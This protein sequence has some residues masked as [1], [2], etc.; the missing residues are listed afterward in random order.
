MISNA[1]VTLIKQ[2]FHKGRRNLHHLLKGRLK[3]HCP[4][5]KTKF[6]LINVRVISPHIT[7]YTTKLDKKIL[8]S[9]TEAVVWKRC[10]ELQG[11]KW[12]TVPS[13]VFLIHI[14]LRSSLLAIFFFY[15]KIIKQTLKQASGPIHKNTILQPGQCF[16]KTIFIQA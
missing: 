5:E 3:G 11:W 16:F 1:P 15:F 12:I 6:C 9:K 4:V 8:W 14:S 10:A 2:A 13:F 7:K